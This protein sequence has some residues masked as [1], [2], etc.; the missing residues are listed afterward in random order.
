MKN[1]KIKKIKKKSSQPKLIQITCDLRYEAR[2]TQ[3]KGKQSKSRNFRPNNSMLN[4]ENEEKNQLFKK[5]LK[6][7]NLNRVYRRNW[8]IVL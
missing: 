4:D 1:D 2:I 5:T 7:S 3:Q 8:W 6:I